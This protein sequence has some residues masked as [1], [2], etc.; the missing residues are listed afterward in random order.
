MRLYKV[1][2]ILILVSSALFLC[3]IELTPDD[4]SDMRVSERIANKDIDYTGCSTPDLVL[5]TEM[6][7]RSSR[8]KDAV[9]AGGKALERQLTEDE[10]IAV[11]YWMGR[12]YECIPD[13]G[14]VA[15][16]TLE[17]S[18]TL[19][20][21]SPRI[22]KTAHRLAQLNTYVGLKDTT[23]NP[24]RAIQL[25][26][27]II[28]LCEPGKVYYEVS[29]AHTLLGYLHSDKGDNVTARTHF[30]AV[31]NIDLETIEPAPGMRFE[32]QAD[33]DAFKE[34]VKRD[35]SWARTKMPAYI[36]ST[37]AGATDADTLAA[38]GELKAR[39]ASDPVMTAEADKAVAA[40]TARIQGTGN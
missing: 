10:D 25:C 2:V 9:T 4:G 35:I 21:S 1:A 38:L 28:S 20:P 5:M 12:A 11:R 31:Y 26:E 13:K 33:V 15:M 17:E 36:V 7:V 18:L 40:V 14:P 3:A 16:Q 23:R 34:Q 37:C 32:T 30:E 29:C 8:P 22:T 19:H 24:E 39:Y 6:L 27:R